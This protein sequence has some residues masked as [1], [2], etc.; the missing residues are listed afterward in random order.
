[1]APMSERVLSIQ[2]HVVFGYVGGKAAVFPLQCLGYD[3]DVNPFSQGSRIFFFFWFDLIGGQYRQLLE[4][5]WLWSFWRFKDDS[6][7][8]EFYIWDYGGEWVAYAYSSID[9]FLSLSFQTW[10]GLSQLMCLIGYIPGAEA[11]SAIHKLAEKLKRSKSHLI[12]LLDRT[13]EKATLLRFFSFCADFCLG[14]SCDGRCRSSI[15]RSGCD[16]CL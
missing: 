4:P 6:C 1:M 2:S 9:R 12:Y 8:V 13:F 3:V 11:L 15:R 10:G 5:C 14:F 7:R 16:T